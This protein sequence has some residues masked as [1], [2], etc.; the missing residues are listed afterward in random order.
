MYLYTAKEFLKTEFTITNPERG[1]KIFWGRMRVKLCDE[2]KSLRNNIWKSLSVIYDNPEYHEFVL[3]LLCNARI[4]DLEAKDRLELLQSDFETIYTI[5]ENKKTLSFDDALVLSH[6]KNLLAQ[7]DKGDDD[8]FKKFQT[9]YEYMIYDLFTTDD[10]TKGTRKELEERRDAKILEVVRTYQQQDFNRMFQACSEIEKN[11]HGNI[12]VLETGIAKVF[13]ALE[14]DSHH[15][16][17]V[18]KDYFNNGAPYGGGQ[19]QIVS[20]LI[21][22]LGYEK[23]FEIIKNAEFAA[24]YQWLYFLWIVIPEETITDDVAQDCISFQR[25]QL[26]NKDNPIIL[27]V[28]QIKRYVKYDRKILKEITEFLIANPIRIQKFLLLACRGDEI[29]EI[30]EVFKDNM[31][32]LENLYFACEK[33]NY[34]YDGSLFWLIYKNNETTVWEKI[35]AELKSEKVRNDL[36][37]YC[38]IFRKIWIMPNYSA[39]IDYAF[40]ELV[41]GTYGL[42]QDEMSIIFS[43][44]KDD[45]EEQKKKQWI[46]DKMDRESGNLNA[47]IDLIDVV[48]NIYPLWKNDVLIRFLEIDKDL[49]HFKKLHLFKMID[50]WVGSEIPV[51]NNQVDFLKDLNS[52]IKGIDYIGHKEYLETRIKQLQEYKKDVEIR[53]YIESGMY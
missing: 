44:E 34:D 12:W 37:Y 28:L 50:G 6:F 9:C 48:V 26:Q 46:W 11:G 31:D 39:R 4:G 38:S 49:D 53:E 3:D 47:L 7:F 13:E 15:Y 19:W 51:I 24:K 16:T 33:R 10:L 23:T 27:S 35:I 32:L 5:F 22:S 8:R 18:L 25:Q 43:K 36:Y 2:I 1:R 21:S 20:Y 45:P 29:L 14:T 17:N 40:K 52:K 42:S 41:V 30:A